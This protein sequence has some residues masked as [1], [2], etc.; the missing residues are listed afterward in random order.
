MASTAKANT[1]KRKLVPNSPTWIPL[2]VNLVL[3][4]IAGMLYVYNAVDMPTVKEINSLVPSP[5]PG[6]PLR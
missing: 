4:F 5:L 2:V 1:M 3:I 6:A